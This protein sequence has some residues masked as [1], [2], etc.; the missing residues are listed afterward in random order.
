MLF[1]PVLLETHE[2]LPLT[3]LLQITHC[4]SKKQLLFAQ[5][6]SFYDHADIRKASLRLV[7]ALSRLCE[8]EIFSIT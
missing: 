6:G 8:Y 7:E 5:S 1:F 3:D 2:Q 4:I